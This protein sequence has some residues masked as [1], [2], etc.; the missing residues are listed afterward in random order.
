VI[1]E[2]TIQLLQEVT[3]RLP[4]VMTKVATVTSSSEA[5]KQSDVVTTTTNQLPLFM[6]KYDIITIATELHVLS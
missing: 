3:S 4:P 6:K 2:Q 5:P 1:I